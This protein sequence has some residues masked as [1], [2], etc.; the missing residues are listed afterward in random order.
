MKINKTFEHFAAAFEATVQDDDWSRLEKYLADDATYQ[1]IGGPEPKWEGRAEI[2]AN[3]KQ[4]IMNTDRR[5]DSRSLV[6]L[7][8]PSVDGNHLSRRWRCT[9][10]L[11]GAPDLVVEGEARYVFEGDLIK[12]IEEEPVAASMQRLSEWM[13]HYGDRLQSK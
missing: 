8:A 10:T 11:A 1:N 4:D 5:F 12:S 7:T 13:Q 6:A 3:L 2:L 9:Y